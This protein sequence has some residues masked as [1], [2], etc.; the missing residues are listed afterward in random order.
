[1]FYNLHA[2]QIDW[3]LEVLIYTLRCHEYSCHCGTP[4]VL[5]DYLQ[6]DHRTPVVQAVPPRCHYTPPKFDTIF[7]LPSWNSF[8][9]EFKGQ[10]I[11][12]QS[13]QCTLILVLAQTLLPLY[14]ERWF[15]ALQA[16]NPGV[17]N[18]LSWC[19]TEWIIVWVMVNCHVDS[20]LCEK[21]EILQKSNCCGFCA[22]M[23]PELI[24]IHTGV[25]FGY[26][27]PTEN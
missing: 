5:A 14:K 11:F 2:Y 10:A 27:A 15:A 9:N 1:M 8:V 22:L 7:I 24:C 3:S 25:D 23:I 26:G 6:C 16:Y 12:P 19:Q 4:A 13:W 20:L 18:P 21:V 17:Y